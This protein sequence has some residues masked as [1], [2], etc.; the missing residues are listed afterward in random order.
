MS[1]SREKIYRKSIIAART[2]NVNMIILILILALITVV[3]AV[4]VTGV[5]GSA[6][7]ILAR[8]YAIEAVNKIDIYISQDL[9]LI[10]KVAHSK[11]VTEWFADEKNQEKK[12]AAFNEIM[13]F[14]D[15]IQN[16]ELYIGIHESLNEFS[17]LSGSTL[18]DFVSNDTL[19][20]S[21][22]VND[23]YYECINSPHDYNLKID[24]DK[25]SNSW[26]LW[27]NHKV[28]L[29]KKI[30]GV[31]CSG[32]EIDTVLNDV[33]SQYDNEDVKGFVIDNR[34][35]IKMDSA[36]YNI[37]VEENDIFIHMA[38]PDPV[39]ALTI[40]SF[41]E[42]IDG[43]FGSRT[44]PDVI[45][46]SKGP[47]GYASIAPISYSDWSVVTLFN[48]RSLFSAIHFLPLLL[49]MLAAFIFY[50]VTNSI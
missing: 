31:F 27:V 35:R 40:N 50:T 38:S 48:S 39:F 5:T 29:N 12:L 14:A 3:A 32:L 24:L 37:H 1:E 42:K 11:V 22:P 6:S 18:A 21:N 10:Q 33:F 46:L 30:L 36:N 44:Q 26:R 9:S 4:I 16:A 2:R 23:W 7:G 28:M 49:V 20:L 34:G 25:F 45:K 13:D 47:Y 8:F 15:L 17:L 41:L 19:D 43:Y